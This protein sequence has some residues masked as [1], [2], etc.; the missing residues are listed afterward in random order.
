MQGATNVAQHMNSVYTATEA[1]SSMFHVTAG[2]AV[3]LGNALQKA[4]DAANPDVYQALGGA[5]NVVN[6]R[7]GALAATGLQVGKSF[8][9]F[10]AKVV[11]DF[12]ATGGRART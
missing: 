3:G 6:E 1:T 12:S 11:Q 10:T 4:Q 2:H 9:T 8:D 7:F 5:V